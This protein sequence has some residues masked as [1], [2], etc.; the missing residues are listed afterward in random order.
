M[1]AR[2]EYLIFVASL[3]AIP[4]E[5]RVNP[6]PGKDTHIEMEQTTPK[7]A[8]PYTYA[9]GRLFHM[10]LGVVAL[11][12]ARQ[13]LLGHVP[14]QRRALLISNPGGGLSLLETLSRNTAKELSNSGYR[15]TALYGH[16][17]QRDE[18]RRLLPGED[19]FVWE[20]HYRTLIDDYGFLSW[21]EPL[22]PALVFLQS[23]LALNET[24]AQ[25]LLR[26]GSRC[27][28]ERTSERF[29]Q[30]ISV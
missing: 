21:D 13:R 9:T 8:E 20:G 30:T 25:P 17:V 11:M 18:V 19:I 28:L 10:D 7:G 27:H 15:T 24:E 16:D 4:T 5:R 12:L 2:A 14:G 29:R 26:R 3:K 6:V 22:R 23:C 1:L